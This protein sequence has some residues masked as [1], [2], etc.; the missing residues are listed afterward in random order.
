MKKVQL[1]LCAGTMCYVMGGANLTEIGNL[2]NE[3]EKQQV[4]I[5]LSPC[6]N[7][8][9]GEKHPPYAEINGQIIQNATKEILI[10]IIKEKIKN[11]VR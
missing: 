1:K 3:E 2:L 8:C 4:D 9:N 7:Q 11:A 10:Q 5:S 6:L